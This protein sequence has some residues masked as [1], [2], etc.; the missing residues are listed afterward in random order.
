MLAD[1]SGRQISRQPAYDE[2]DLAFAEEIG[3]RA[4]IA[5]EN[6]RMYERERR[7]A[8]Q[9]Q[10]ASLPAA[11]PRIDHLHLDADYRPGS[12]EATIGGDWYD[13]FAV[14]TRRVMITVGDVL[15][16][17]LQAAVT[18]TKLRQAMQSAAMVNPDPNVMLAVADRTLR[19]LD[20]DGYATAVA[21]LYDRDLHTVTFASAGHPG[22][23]MRTPGGDVFE[24]TS[25]GLMLGLRTGAENDTTVVPAP[26]GTTLVFFT[27]GL[28]E[29][30]RD[31]EAGQQRLMAAVGGAD[32][33]TIERP[34]QAIAN[35][36]LGEVI[37]SDDVA[38]LVARVAT[39]PM[40]PERQTSYPTISD[41]RSDPPL[42][43]T[44]ET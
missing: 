17:G 44:N 6:A 21:A 33:T 43:A 8:V 11:L 14:D 42:D 7:I 31:Y 22:P 23:I 15:G 18:M 24:F 39:I 34:A 5:I 16:H 40:T 12:S 4:G 41:D 38:L 2:D 3:R 19:M 1:E 28:V 30:T 10:A 27:D 35:A 25:P 13:A 36:V 9:L 26:P 20:V 32:F 37:S 29:A